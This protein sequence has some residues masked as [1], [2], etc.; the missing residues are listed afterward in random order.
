MRLQAAPGERPVTHR[1]SH[2]EYWAPGKSRLKAVMFGEVLCSSTP[3][4]QQIKLP[5]L[6]LTVTVFRQQFFPDVLSDQG[7]PTLERPSANTHNHFLSSRKD[8]EHLERIIKSERHYE[9]QNTNHG[10][11][12][13]D[14]VF[15]N[16][17][18]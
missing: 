3:T 13:Q 4:F 5:R 11:Q 15:S 9:T 6:A 12:M 1:Q 16:I 10:E 14:P 7:N 8:Q 18:D 2:L 17:T